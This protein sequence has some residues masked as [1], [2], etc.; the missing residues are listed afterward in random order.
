MPK[1]LVKNLSEHR[2]VSVGRLKWTPGR[3]MWVDEELLGTRKVQSLL[4]GGRF[5]VLQTRGL[6]EPEPAAEEP[7]PVVVE[8]PVVEEVPS[9]SSEETPPLTKSQLSSMKVAELRKLASSMEIFTSG[10][11]K[12]ELIEAILAGEE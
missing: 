5:A 9:P 7:S 10:L 8:E 3:Q 12:A 4:E 1:Y 2:S 11:R 6:P